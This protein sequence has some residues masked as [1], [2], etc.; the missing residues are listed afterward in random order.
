MVD[1]LHTRRS[2]APD[3][4]AAGARPRSSSWLTH[5]A[6]TMPETARVLGQARLPKTIVLTGALR[7]P[8][9]FG[10]SDGLFNLGSAL[11][12][13]QSLPP[14]VY[15][16]MNGLGSLG[17]RA[18]EQGPVFV[19]LVIRPAPA[20][21]P[22]WPSAAS[23]RPAG[24]RHPGRVRHA[25]L[26]RGPRRPAAAAALSSVAWPLR[27]SPGG[28]SRTGTTPRTTPCST[29]TRCWGRPCWCCRC[30]PWAPARCCSSTPPRCSACSLA[31]WGCFCLARRLG[32]GPAGAFLAG[33]AVPYSSQQMER[34]VHLNLLAIP[35]LPW[36]LLGL[37]QLVEAPRASTPAL[38]GRPA[39]RAA[40]GHQRLPRLR[41][42]LMS[43]AVAAW[44]WRRLRDPRLVA[45]GRLALLV[46][47]TR[48]Y[49]VREPLRSSATRLAWSAASRSSAPTAWTSPACSPAGPGS[50]AGCCRATR[51]SS[52]G[53][54]CCF[55]QAS[56]C[57]TC[58]ASATSA[59]WPYR[60]A[61]FVMA[62]GPEVRWRGAVLAPAPFALALR[63]VPAAR[64]DAPPVIPAVPRDRW[65]CWRHLGLSAVGVARRP[66]LMA[67][68]LALA[69]L[70]TLTDAPARRRPRASSAPVYPSWRTSSPSSRRRPAG[71]RA[72]AAHAGHE[73]TWAP[74]RA[75]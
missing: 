53:R 12:F 68:L 66:W 2:T 4:R 61:T 36:L 59:C 34:L 44:G 41:A 72:R 32:A 3:R 71:G 14:G 5:G 29:A 74:C 62:L 38:G 70:E 30:G 69:G 55:C 20:G 31:S 73:L 46:A 67:A 51:P 64:G 48:L 42:A 10:S 65:P 54:S 35:F 23:A 39:L 75:T 50:G 52:R 60:A 28:R 16:A 7:W 57:S 1:G 21:W 8:N 19:P 37:V 45:C 40:G 63:A 25:Q 27:A 26:R 22:S 18:Q 13:E 24:G 11:S 17:Q 56:R 6:D 49:P 33:I 58:A 43:L 15:V 9:A 47:A